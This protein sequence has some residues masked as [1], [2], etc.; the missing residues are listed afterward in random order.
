MTSQLKVAY[1]Y[2]FTEYTT[3]TEV[4]QLPEPNDRFRN[5]SSMLSVGIT[6]QF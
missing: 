5:K 2:L 1:Q 3:D 6:K 4:Q